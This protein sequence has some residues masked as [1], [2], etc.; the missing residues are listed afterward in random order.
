MIELK[1]SN[2]DKTTLLDDCDALRLGGRRVQLSSRGYAQFGVNGKTIMLHR[3]VLRTRD[4]YCH[5][6]HINNLKLDNRKENLREVT[7]NYNAARVARKPS[8][9]G[10]R[11]VKA[12][13]SGKRKIYCAHFKLNGREFVSKGFKTPFQAAVEAQNI[14]ELNRP[15][16]E[17]CIPFEKGWVTRLN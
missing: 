8:K 11:N 1:F 10:F 4:I 5:V 3:Y 17:V 12:F 6:D 15:D 9:N 13:S 16:I 14:H 7:A 2:S